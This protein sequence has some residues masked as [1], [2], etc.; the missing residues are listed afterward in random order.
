VKTVRNEHASYHNLDSEK[1]KT[2]ARSNI[3][4]CLVSINGLPCFPREVCHRE[5]SQAWGEKST[6]WSDASDGIDH[7]R[8]K[9]LQHSHKSGKDM[10]PA[11]L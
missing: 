7:F 9:S 2:E 4:F 6:V 3:C 5:L 8:P 1:Q 10:L 11:T